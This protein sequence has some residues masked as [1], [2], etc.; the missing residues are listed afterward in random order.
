MEQCSIFRNYDKVH[1]STFLSVWTLKNFH[2]LHSN[3]DH[4][5]SSSILSWTRSTSELILLKQWYLTNLKETQVS[6]VNLSLASTWAIPSGDFKCSVSQSCPTLC[7]SMDCSLLSSFVH[8]ISQA[9]ILEWVAI[10]HL[11]G[12]FP[13]Q[14]LNPC[15]LWLLHWQILYHW[16]TCEVQRLHDLPLTHGI[17]RVELGPKGISM[18]IWDGPSTCIITAIFQMGSCGPNWKW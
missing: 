2:E 13:T 11:Q 18:N 5:S 16:A 1:F 14:A 8:G 6:K 10:F 12:I 4:T 3:I 9:R 15:L 17:C 7:D